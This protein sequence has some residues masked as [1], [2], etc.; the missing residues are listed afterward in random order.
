MKQ[1]PLLMLLLWG[2]TTTG[3]A[4]PYPNKIFNF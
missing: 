2:V 4:L 1:N 3:D